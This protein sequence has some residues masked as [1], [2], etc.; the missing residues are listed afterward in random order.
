M[1]P[2]STL[3]D[4]S[5]ATGSSSVVAEPVGVS[6]DSTEDEA[7]EDT[8]RSTAQ[9]E[10]HEDACSCIAFYIIISAV[11]LAMFLA[12]FAYIVGKTSPAEEE[13]VRHVEDIPSSSADEDEL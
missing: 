13:D 8:G 10:R 3:L 11:I 9:S 2:R 7:E 6:H 4:S 12:V 5:Q 1:S